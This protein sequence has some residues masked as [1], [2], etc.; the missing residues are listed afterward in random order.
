MSQIMHESYLHVHRRFHSIS[1]RRKLFFFMSTLSSSDECDSAA[2]DQALAQSMTDYDL[3]SGSMYLH[4]RT[5]VENEFPLHTIVSVRG[6][7][8]CMFDSVALSLFGADEVEVRGQ[9]LREKT[10]KAYSD[11]KMMMEKLTLRLVDPDSAV[12]YVDRLFSTKVYVEEMDIWML[13]TVAN[14]CIQIYQLSAGKIECRS[15]EHGCKSDGTIVRVFY[16]RSLSHYSP[17]ISTLLP[18]SQYNFH[19]ADVV[20]STKGPSML[21]SPFAETSIR[22]DSPMI[23]AGEL[24]AAL[25]STSSNVNVD[26]II[27]TQATASSFNEE[28][29]VVVEENLV[30]QSSLSSAA[31]SSPSAFSSS[32]DTNNDVSISHHC[33]YHHMFFLMFFR[34]FPGGR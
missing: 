3:Y 10:A 18:S 26:D 11:D 34:S 20:L 8:N 1:Y 29:V 19:D 27:S 13:E 12:K 28:D 5:A 32:S 25:P 22:V 24:S 16:H 31:S 21:I 30:F 33:R 7:G 14:V 15:R 23:E 9:L 4:D 6:T 17:I 2:F